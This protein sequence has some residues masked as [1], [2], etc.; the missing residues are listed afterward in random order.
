M[1]LCKLASLCSDE[2]PD[3]RQSQI[4]TQVSQD[5]SAELI[6]GAESWVFVAGSCLLGL[7]QS[8]HFLLSFSLSLQLPMTA[9]SVF[10]GLSKSV[11][12][13]LFWVSSRYCCTALRTAFSTSLLLRLSNSA[14]SG[15]APFF[16][17]THHN[18]QKSVNLCRWGN[19]MQYT[20]I[21]T[22]C[23]ASPSCDVQA[24]PKPPECLCL[25]STPGS[26]SKWKHK[27]A[28]F[29]PLFFCALTF[30]ES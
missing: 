2:V 12:L 11:S 18:R 19:G 16:S 23:S 13:F 17:P 7:L 25:L 14:S 22:S 15:S 3:N 28:A 5:S 10:T 26:P 9:S 6:Q 27:E 8:T 24:H 29:S 20:S 21:G 1:K 4:P 30:H